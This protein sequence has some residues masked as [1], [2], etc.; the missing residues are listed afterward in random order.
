MEFAEA[1]SIDTYICNC[2]TMDLYIFFEHN[3]FL[4]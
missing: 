3:D 4:Y 2:G 1:Q